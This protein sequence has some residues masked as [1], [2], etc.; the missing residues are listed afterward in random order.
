MAPSHAAEMLPEA[1]GHWKEA[2]NEAPSHNKL[3]QL[4]SQAPQGLHC[5]TVILIILTQVS[6]TNP[7]VPSSG[8][9]MAIVLLPLLP[10]A[11]VGSQTLP[12]LLGY[13][14]NLCPCILPY[15]T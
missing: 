13:C 2:H 4:L 11:L 8:M 9:S 6:R 15:Q 12:K 14:I 5:A 10:Q 7:H 3:S 1:S